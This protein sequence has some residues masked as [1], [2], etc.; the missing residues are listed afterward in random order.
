MTFLCGTVTEFNV[1]FPDSPLDPIYV[2]KQSLEISTKK[3]RKKSP[4]PHISKAASS[5]SSSSDVIMQENKKKKQ[6]L[7]SITSQS[8]MLKIILVLIL[9]STCGNSHSRLPSPSSGVDHHPLIFF[10]QAELGMVLHRFP[11]WPRVIQVLNPYLNCL[12]ASA[13]NPGYKNHLDRDELCV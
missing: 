6:S 13:I 5:V 1:T 4:D 8:N 3:R 12:L 10:R 2:T 7:P 11:R 9:M